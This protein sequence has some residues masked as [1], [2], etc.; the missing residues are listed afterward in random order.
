MN[1]PVVG[2][3]FRRVL[4]HNNK[5]TIGVNNSLALVVY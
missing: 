4:Q 5:G 1:V 3:L 2:R